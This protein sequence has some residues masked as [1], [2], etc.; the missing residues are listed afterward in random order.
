MVFKL[1]ISR[2]SWR[3]CVSPGSKDEE[4]VWMRALE[5]SS[6]HKMKSAV[7]KPGG[8]AWRGREMGSPNKQTDYWC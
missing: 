4:V 6:H 8:G 2:L 5:N 7:W 3:F 1:D